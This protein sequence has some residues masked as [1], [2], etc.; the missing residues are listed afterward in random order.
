MTENMKKFIELVSKDEVLQEKLNT[1]QEQ[2]EQENIKAIIALASEYGITLTEVDFQNAKES[3]EL[4]EEELTSVAG[5]NG[6]Y[7]PGWGYG[8][9][10]DNFKEWNCYCVGGGL[11]YADERYRTDF[12]MCVSMGVGIDG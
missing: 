6:C 4:S 8:Y 3:G 11:S 7:C 1:V 5:G 10:W 2:E 9:G 12:C